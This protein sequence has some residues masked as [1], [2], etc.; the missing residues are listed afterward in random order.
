[1]EN[2]T[3]KNHGV[4]T[5]KESTIVM[6]KYRIDLRAMHPKKRSISN[7]ISLKMLPHINK[8]SEIDQTINAPKGPKWPHKT[9]VCVVKCTIFFFQ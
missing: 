9:L 6:R 3:G 8:N 1:M 4:A 2:P 5:S 7:Y